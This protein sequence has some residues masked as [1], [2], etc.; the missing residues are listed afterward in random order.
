[1]FNPTQDDVRRFFCETYR[2]TVAREILTPLE[3]IASDW[4][5]EHPEYHAD[6]ADLD[7]A[8]EAEYPVEQGRTNPF[9]H[10]SMHLSLAEQVSVNQPP[11]ITPVFRELAQHQ[12]SAH[13]AHHIMME[14]L[15]AMV[16]ESQRD[17]T[18]FDG[19]AYVAALKQK[20]GRG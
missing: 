1:M 19:A 3:T 2:K 4:I 20:T 7:A 13:Q 11:G 10:L 12:Q 8:L 17:G 5:S 14:S 18:P 9:L 15:G 16:W 6:L